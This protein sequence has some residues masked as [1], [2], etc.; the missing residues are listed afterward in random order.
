M[1]I[2]YPDSISGY[3]DIRIL[4]PDIRILYPKLVCFGYHF[5][6][7]F[8]VVHIAAKGAQPLEELHEVNISTVILVEDICE[9]LSAKIF[10]GQYLKFNI[11][12]S[13]RLHYH[14]LSKTSARYCEPKYS[15][16]Q[17]G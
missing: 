14:P 8:P 6:E 15:I 17:M 4:Y 11:E 2:L 12:N 3:P 13:Q 9:I 5:L 16:D 7:N 1:K 10:N